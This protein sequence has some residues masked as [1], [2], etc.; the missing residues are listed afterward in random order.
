MRKD[1]AFFGSLLSFIV[2]VGSGSFLTAPLIFIWCVGTALMGAVFC[3]FPRR[4]IFFS[5]LFFSLFLGGAFLISQA[6]FGFAHLTFPTTER[7]GEVRVISN[8]E[9]KSFFQKI[10]VRFTDCDGEC[11]TKDILWQAPVSM[12]IEAGERLRFHCKLTAP[13]NFSADFDYRMS[14][15]K[16]GVGFLCQHATVAEKLSGDR[17]GRLSASL[18]VLKHALERALS[19]TLP[20]PEAGLAKGLLLGGSGY[21]P[22]ALQNAFTRVGLTHIVAVS[23]YNITLIAQGLF[24]L[25]LFFGLWRKQALW[26]AFFGIIFFILMIGAPASATRAGFMAGVAFAALQAGRLARP[27]NALLLAAAI[28]LLFNPLLLRYD[29]GFQLSFLATMGIVL[30]SPYLARVLPEKLLA[31]SVCEILLMTLA[32]ELFVLPIILFSFHRFS[33]LIIVANFLIIVVPFAMAAS[34]VAGVLYILLPGA[35]ILFAWLAFALLT[36]ITRSVEWLGAIPSAS[37]TVENF[38]VKSLVLWYGVLFFLVRWGE[39][40]YAQKSY[41]FEE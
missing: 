31:K 20:E 35:H 29:I 18:Y 1:Q 25:G 10:I 6:L 26:V 30:V 15:A 19:Q 21:L 40:H 4:T 41:D 5:W 39:K 23:G 38:G 28:M 34:F 3:V 16:D 37:V 8:P 24:F 2:G 32:V 9:E 11:P 27:L 14:L 12:T 36:F 22:D 33:P 7:V 17:T 13:E